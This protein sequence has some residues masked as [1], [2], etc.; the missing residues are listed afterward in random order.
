MGFISGS[1]HTSDGL[2]VV[3]RGEFYLEIDTVYVS[4]R[5]RSN[6]IGGSLV[7]QMLVQ[8]NRQ[9]MAYILIYSSTK[10]IHAVLKFYESHGFRS[11]YV[12][13]FQKL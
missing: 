3:P 7:D 9:E 11:W 2:A 13:M 1:S 5:F 6:G 8:A 10:D 12:Q 4:P